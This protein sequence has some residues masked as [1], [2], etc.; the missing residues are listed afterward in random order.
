MLFVKRQVFGVLYLSNMLLCFW[1]SSFTPQTYRLYFLIVFHHRHIYHL[2]WFC[3]LSLAWG[4]L[5]ILRD[6][7]HVLSGSWQQS[8]IF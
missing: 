1:K 6:H 4:R 8:V 2:A 3:H 7:G 5:S